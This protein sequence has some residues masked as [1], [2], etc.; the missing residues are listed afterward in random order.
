MDISGYAGC[1]SPA[2]SWRV[3]KRDHHSGATLPVVSS[4]LL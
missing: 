2:E 3:V 1:A 4:S